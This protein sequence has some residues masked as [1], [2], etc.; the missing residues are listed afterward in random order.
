MPV[1]RAP[2]IA[3]LVAAVSLAGCTGDAAD[4]SASIYVKDAPTDVFA[5]V[6]VVITE[7]SVHVAGGGDEGEDEQNETGEAALDEGNDTGGA[8]WK[9]LADSDGGFD[10]DLLNASGTN[11]AF[12]GEADLAAGRYTQ[13]RV[14][15]DSAYGITHEGDRLNISVP[16]QALRVVRSF[17]VEE[18]QE[19]RIILDID[20]EASLRQQGDEWRLRP[21]VGTTMVEVV[22]DAGSG[23]DV[24]EEGEVAPVAT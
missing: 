13:I 8:G 16:S 17:E 15:V 12:L 23:E 14:Q 10:V 9:V 21:V 7:V 2:S 24:H 20:L 4:G 22:E 1:P 6:H 3:L 18:G 11:A 19:T 5:E